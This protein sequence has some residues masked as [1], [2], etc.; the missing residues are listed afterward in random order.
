[1]WHSPGEMMSPWS[2]RAAA[3]AGG[4]GGSAFLSTSQY[5]SHHQLKLKL[6]TCT[7]ISGKKETPPLSEEV[8]VPNYLGS[9]A[10]C[11]V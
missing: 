9:Y 4:G 11:T 3:A 6:A 5:E 7:Y 8:Y 2:G 10:V 1:M